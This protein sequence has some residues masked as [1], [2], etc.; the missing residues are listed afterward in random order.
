MLREEFLALLEEYEVDLF[1]IEIR[2]DHARAVV[3]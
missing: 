2:R 1:Q 3:A